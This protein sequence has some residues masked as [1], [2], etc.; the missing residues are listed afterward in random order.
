[1]CCAPAVSLVHS[2]VGNSMIY[3]YTPVALQ[4]VLAEGFQPIHHR[5][6]GTTDHRVASDLTPL[7]YGV[8]N[9]TWPSSY[10]TCAENDVPGY[11]VNTL[12]NKAT[13]CTSATTV[14]SP[15]PVPRPVKRMR[16]ERERGDG[17]KKKTL[18][19]NLHSYQTQTRG[20][21]DAEFVRT[22]KRL[23]PKV[24]RGNKPSSSRSSSS[25]K[26]ERTTPTL[27]QSSFA[28]TERMS[29]T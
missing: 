15:H 24:Y 27:S 21:D 10:A 7:R 29:R 26:V 16:R 3:M 17:K 28:S 14:I 11:I 4:L 9:T 19:R 12:L 18:R 1:M 22:D 5:R 25:S 20:T 13:H 2:K 8:S 23:A 6:I